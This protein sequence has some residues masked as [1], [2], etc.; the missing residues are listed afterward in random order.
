[1]LS[2]WTTCRSAPRPPPPLPPYLGSAPPARPPPPPRSSTRCC[3]TAV[4][5]PTAAVHSCWTSEPTSVTLPFS[6]RCTAAGEGALGFLGFPGSP[7]EGV[8]GFSR[9]SFSFCCDDVFSPAWYL[10]GGLGLF[11]GWPGFRVL[12]RQ[13]VHLAV[14]RIMAPHHP[15]K[16]E[17]LRI[18]IRP[19]VP[20]TQGADVPVL[21]NPPT[22]CVNAG[23]WPGSLSPYSEHSSAIICR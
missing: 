13:S 17:T 4:C 23:W 18:I 12:G 6:R 3:K 2:P 19:L 16:P 20:C 22:L 8:D 5:V 14:P 10:V 9:D 15:I 11:M 7:P 1:M 21:G